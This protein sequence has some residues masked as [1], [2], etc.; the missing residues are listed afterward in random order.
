MA[1]EE[2]LAILH[3]GVEQWN[4]WR[5]DNPD[6]KIDLSGASLIRADLSE[7]NLIEADLEWA[8]LNQADLSGALLH[9]AHLSKAHLSGANLKGAHLEGAIL[10]ETSLQRADLTGAKFDSK[11]D[12]ERARVEGCKVERHQLERLEGYGG[13]T[14]GAMM[15]MEIEDGVVTLRAS[16]SGFMQWVHLVALAVFL[17]PYVWFIVSQWSKARFVSAGQSVFPE[18]DG[19]MPL[20]KALSYFIYNG[21]LEWQIGPSLHWTF[22]LF[23]LM[24]VYNALRT[25]LLWKTKSLEN[26]QTASGLRANFSLTDPV[27]GHSLGK[28]YRPGHWFTWGL[29][30]RL[31]QWGFYTAI[32]I[33]LLNTL[34]FFGQSI[35]IYLP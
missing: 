11:T 27:I 8:K 1:N 12:L 5:E 17:F 2:Q 26:Y 23:I 15:D 20:W 14:T 16:Y 33:A 28:E 32:A 31:S 25:V 3:K 7:A 29:L 19:Q 21:G 30:L 35:P 24:F 34:H 18:A 13:L 22:G 6:E 4:Q 9:V 10:S